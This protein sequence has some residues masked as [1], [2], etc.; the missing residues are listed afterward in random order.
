MQTS[1]EG[2][3][4]EAF[5]ETFNEPR[6]L[7]Q[8]CYLI[9]TASF[10]HSNT[11]KQCSEL[12]FCL[13]LK[14]HLGT[15]H[16]CEGRKE[17]R[18]TTKKTTQTSDS[19]LT[20]AGSKLL[21]NYILGECTSQTKLSPN[22]ESGRTALYYSFIFRTRRHSFSWCR[23]LHCHQ[24]HGIRLLMDFTACLIELYWK[25]VPWN[26]EICAFLTPY[27]IGLVRNHTITSNTKH[28]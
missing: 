16:L 1:S 15:T 11:Q 2:N 24:I 8:W 17:V 6:N 13:L 3:K 5:S 4:E 21:A 12:N 27:S 10:R 9:F 18:I 26:T 19:G 22:G 23:L 28:L 14:K 20:S 7:W 25:T